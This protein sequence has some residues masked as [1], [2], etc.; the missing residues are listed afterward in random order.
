MIQKGNPVP[1]VEI[2][3]QRASGSHIFSIMDAVI[4]NVYSNITNIVV[5]ISDGTEKSKQGAILVNAHYDSTVITP[6]TSFRASRDRRG[7]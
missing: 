4:T 5:R 2:D 3:I 6:G 1:E 7:C